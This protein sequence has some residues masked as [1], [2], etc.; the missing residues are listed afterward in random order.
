VLHS[1]PAGEFVQEL[2][3]RF[4]GPLVAN[5][6]FGVVTNRDD[7]QALIDDGKADAVAVGR[8][9]IANP[10]LVRRW[11]EERE[12]NEPDASTFYGP[13]ARGYTDYPALAS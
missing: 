2:R 5:S 9:L 7:A 10:D 4:A 13:G 6:G 1:D 8:M 3:G 12:L 11:A